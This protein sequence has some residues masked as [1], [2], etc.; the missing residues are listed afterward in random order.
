MKKY[1]LIILCLFFLVGCSGEKSN[2]VN[3]VEAKEKI[4]N[5]GA[6]LLDVRTKDEYDEGHIDGAVLLPLDSISEDS[7]KK[8]VDNNKM[9]IIVYCRSGNRS[10]QALE[11][12]KELGYDNV[13][14]LGAMSN[15][16]E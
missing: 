3:Y 1:L 2:K 7:V 12:L 8:V 4:I 13:F 15:W 5:E 9:V 11:M 16:K 10:A 14:D 6:I